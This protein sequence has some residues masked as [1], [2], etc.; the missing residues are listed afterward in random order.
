MKAVPTRAYIDVGRKADDLSLA[1]P[2]AVWIVPSNFEAMT[3]AGEATY[4]A[5]YDLV[6]KLL[7]GAGLPYSLLK[8]ADGPYP[9]LI[10]QSYEFVALPLLIFT[11][12]VLLSHPGIIQ[13]ALCILLEHLRDKSRSDPGKGQHNVK[14]KIVK[15]T[16]GE[17]VR[18][19]YDG[20]LEGFGDFIEAVK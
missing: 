18:A 19:D 17:Y 10:Q 3:S 20:P 13:Q 9:K 14:C 4:A 2:D 11:K 16:A 7:R 1:V 8:S 12:D 5:D 15:S 6:V